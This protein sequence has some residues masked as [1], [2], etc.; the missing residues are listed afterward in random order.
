MILRIAANVSVWDMA[1]IEFF[2]PVVGRLD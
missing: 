1:A 2:S